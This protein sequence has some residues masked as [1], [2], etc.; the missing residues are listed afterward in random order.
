MCS[1]TDK[2]VMIFSRPEG[3]ASPKLLVGCLG[4]EVFDGIHH[5][6]ERPALLH[7]G[8]EVNVIGHDDPRDELIAGA[9]EVKEG[10]FDDGGDV[11]AAE[12]AGPVAGVEPGF[13]ALAAFEVAEGVLGASLG[14]FLLGAPPS[15]SGFFIMPEATLIF[16]V[17]LQKSAAVAGS[18][19]AA[20]D[21]GAP[22]DAA[23][24]GGAPGDA[25]R[26]RRRSR[27]LCSQEGVEFFLEAG[28]HGLG[29][30]IA[31]VD[32]DGLDFSGAVEVREV[33]AGV[34]EAVRCV[35]GR[36]GSH[37][38]GGPGS[39]AVLERLLVD[40]GSRILKRTSCDALRKRVAFG[41]LW[42]RSGTA[43][44]PGAAFPESV[45]CGNLL[46]RSGT[47]AVPE[48][49]A[50]G[51]LWSRSGTAVFP[52]AGLPGVV[53]AVLFATA[54]A[55]A[56]VNDAFSARAALVSAV[57][58]TTAGATLEAGELN[59]AGRGGASVWWTW[60]ASSD[61]WVSFSTAGS[62]IDTVLLAFTGTSV[63]GLTYRAGSDDASGGAA[64]G[65]SQIVLRAV[66]GEVIQ[67]AVHGKLGAQGSVALSVTPWVEPE[68]RVSSLAV[69]KTVANVSAGA[70]V[71]T[72]TLGIDGW[73]A[74]GTGRIG[75]TGR[76]PGAGFTPLLDLTAGDTLFGFYEKAVSLPR[77]MPPG[78]YWLE[79]GLS[80]LS[81]GGASL[82]L[83]AGE[84]Q[85][86]PAG[87]PVKI[88][89][90]NT[91]QIDTTPPVLASLA[92]PAGPVDV[93][94]ADRSVTATP[95]AVDDLTGVYS[96]AVGWVQSATGWRIAAGSGL[97]RQEA[98][99]GVYDAEVTLTDLA[100][101][102]KTIRHGLAGWPA[103]VPGTLTV[104][105][106]DPY[107]GWAR[108]RL[109]GRAQDRLADPDGDGLANL[110]EYALGL[111]P[112]TAERGGSPR[113]R[114][115]GTAAGAAARG[116]FVFRR[117]TGASAFGL[118]YVVE[119]G[120]TLSGTPWQSAGL[121]GATVSPLG[122]G[123]EEVSLPLGGAGVR[124]VFARL[125][126][127]AGEGTAP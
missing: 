38:G 102:S 1:I 45:A 64:A 25:A 97:F 109:G 66:A 16:G 53:L 2:P 58:G 18:W 36:G 35:V 59:P 22:G 108:V 31:K 12:P 40:G 118:S 86:F 43:A 100:G 57:S 50:C 9:I 94:R 19:D 124:S 20:R 10:V 17:N 115:D 34:P 103:G 28:E 44:F 117:R 112:A 27:G 75:F 62:G 14:G 5:S 49:V 95:G 111:D 91:G 89:V 67:L 98:P 81:G 106:R 13:D 122:D 105:N 127:T 33:A 88:T 114:L 26:G 85:A 3:P 51:D 47:A 77:G 96:A 92:L 54:A 110:T 83:A 68:P 120:S 8:E 82:G 24:D 79:V 70:D 42:S 123:W 41:N 55:A 71:V 4:G 46:S 32:G 11:R 61:G 6:A 101:N 39:A 93:T 78:D 21:G 90:V 65:G 52:G 113:P 74:F 73:D 60:T 15:S 48:S 107:G 126:I 125:R 37:G 7:L 56:P 116:R 76:L 99:A 84:G 30:G 72:F 69:S 87:A 29:E 119:T 80:R 23:R 121:A 63:S 104:V